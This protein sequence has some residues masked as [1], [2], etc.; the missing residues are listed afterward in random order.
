MLE[1][2]V[3]FEIIDKGTPA[4]GH[5]LRIGTEQFRYLRITHVFSTC[6]YGM[7]VTTPRQARSARRPARI[8]LSE[9]GSIIE[10]KNGQWGKLPLPLPFMRT[11]K[12]RN[13]DHSEA[14]QAAWSL[15]KPLVHAFKDE[16][17]LSRAFF[18]S[19]IRN[20]A[21]TL[22]ISFLT[23]YRLTLRYYYF[24][25][26]RLA[27]LPLPPGARLEE[28][29]YA[30]G[31]KNDPNNTQTHKRRG[32]Q[33]ALASEVGKNNFIISDDDIADM[34]ICLKGCLR[35]GPTFYTNAHETY[36]ATHFR[37]R[38][39]EIFKLYISKNHPEP[40]T[41]RQFR[42]YVD[43]D[44]Q[45]T[46]DLA[47]NLR[48]H[49]RN[50]GRTGAVRATGPGEVYEIDATG[51][52]IYLV[53]ND[54]SPV[55]VG[56]PILYLIIDRWSRFIVSVYL[57]LRPASWSEVQY[58]LLIAF[59]S[60]NRRFASLGVDVDDERWPIGR[61]PSTICSDRGSEF[62]SRSAEK[63]ITNDLRIELTPLPP[64]CPDGKA[65]VER[66]IREIKRRMFMSTLKRHL[67]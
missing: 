6:L 34:V 4:E 41:L 27:L 44:L 51:G 40:V 2:S 43:E 66:V 23:L 36:L 24:G 11:G 9:I 17:N 32:R 35:K 30:L 52:R 53:T 33:A 55:V 22:D 56:T 65:I 63:A 62:M 31:R 20:R 10:H 3:K 21:E 5:V 26:T 1:A 42:Y 19:L 58:A 12:F 28:R 50:P 46:D 8:P 7:W 18:T 29:A 25:G 15:I 16:R 54:E 14:I 47:R 48:K 39:P 38:H 49:E 67:R 37:R 64:L 13:N 57:S 61:F 60:R 59:T 45:L